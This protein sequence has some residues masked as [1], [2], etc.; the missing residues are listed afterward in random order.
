ML[1]KPKSKS[2]A[3]EGAGAPVEG[4]VMER[5]RDLPVR[6]CAGGGGGGKAPEPCEGVDWCDWGPSDSWG[7]KEA[8]LGDGGAYWKCGA[9][10]PGD[11]GG[12]W[13]SRLLLSLDEFGER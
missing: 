4:M 13:N 6:T 11:G 9:L 1:G 3:A 8:L 12:K 7:E 2:A 10:R 5:S